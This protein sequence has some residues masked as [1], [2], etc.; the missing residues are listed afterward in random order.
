M[1]ARPSFYG[2][3]G[4]A[5]F[6]THAPG[7][8]INPAP[9]R[10][11]VYGVTVSFCVAP[12]APAQVECFAAVDRREA[13]RKAWGRIVRAIRSGEAVAYTTHHTERTVTDRREME[14]HHAR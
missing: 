11:V 8:Q 14:L 5:W 2:P 3:P 12:G 4:K 6:A 1:T 9:D 7:V 10:A 13:V